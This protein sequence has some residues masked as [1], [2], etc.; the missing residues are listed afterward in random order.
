MKNILG[1]EEG[2]RLPIPSPCAGEIFIKTPAEAAPGFA[3][4]TLNAGS[5]MPK[6]R[7]DACDLAFFIYKGQA[8]VRAGESAQTVVPGACLIVPRGN[9]CEISNTG[10][11][12]LQLIWTASGASFLDFFRA[13][14][15]DGG[16]AD[17][18]LLGQRY[19]LEFGQPGENE[20]AAKKPRHKHKY[21]Q[22]RKHSKEHSASSAAALPQAVPVSKPQ[23]P[24]APLPVTPP[25]SQPPATPKP[26]PSGLSRRQKNKRPSPK[27]P[28]QGVRDKRSRHRPGKSKMVYM[29]GRWVEVTGEGPVIA[30]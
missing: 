27:Q 26:A 15:T 21:W 7:L 30:Q 24:E 20:T 23:P 3:F 22:R 11:G 1:P 25:V 9:W 18:R 5:L 19:G 16:S 29:G 12:L 2:Q 14:S 10:T 28:S 17:F 6:F 13:W 4:Q 8:R